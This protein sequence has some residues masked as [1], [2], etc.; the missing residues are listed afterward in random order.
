MVRLLLFGPLRSKRMGSLFYRSILFGLSLSLSLSLLS[1]GG[2]LQAQTSQVKAQEQARRLFMRFTGV[3]PSR[4]VLSEMTDHL[5]AGRVLDAAFVAMENNNFY[6]VVLFN[7]FSAYS[8]VAGNSDLD[9]TDYTALALGLIYENER[10]DQVLYGDVLYTAN[11]A[12]MTYNITVN[13]NDVPTSLP[14]N[15]AGPFFPLVRDIDGTSDFAQ[16]PPANKVRP[17]FRAVDVNN[18]TDV[19]YDEN[20]H[21]RDLQRLTNWVGLLQKRS[22][23]TAYSYLRND[24]RV[25]SED[26]AGILTTRQYGSEYFNMGTNRRAFRF[27]TKTFLCKDME[28]LT[29][30][31]APDLR[32]RQDVD[33][34]PGGN[35]NNFRAKCQG[36]HAGMDSFSGA[37][38]YFDYSNGRLIYNRNALQNNN[39][40]QFRQSNVY[41]EG[42]R[43]QNNS[44]IN[45]WNRGPNLAL[46]WRTPA[47]GDEAQGTGAKSLGAALAAT[48]QFG[49]CMAQKAFERICFRSPTPRETS[50]LE[51]LAREFEDGWDELSNYSASNPYNMRGLFAKVSSMCFG[52]GGQ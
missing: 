26:V 10:F 13:I 23:A 46:G 14:V 22:Q 20:T 27:A 21:Y 33:R 25:A 42:H 35:S 49:N 43:L 39:N 28:Q 37:F 32:V 7:M 4:A 52:S 15:R 3:P 5:A 9:L 50:E 38:A 18:P 29:D 31:S 30:T 1:M 44:W 36:C 6:Q 48:E 40:K 12:A 17:I 2:P 11:D 41:P 8:N 45:L 47:V 16:N 19:R 34:S 51:N 24:A